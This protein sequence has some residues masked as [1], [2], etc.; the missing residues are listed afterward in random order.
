MVLER[1]EEGVK[2]KDELNQ[3]SNSAENM[4]VYRSFTEQWYLYWHFNEIV[5]EP[6]ES[7]EWRCWVW[8]VWVKMWVLV[9]PE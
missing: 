2:K 3:Y 8:D 1:T 5:I 6:D 9:G 4:M 7:T